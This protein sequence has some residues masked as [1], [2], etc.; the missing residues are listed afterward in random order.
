MRDDSGISV[1][2]GNGDGTFQPAMTIL[3]PFP[4]TAIGIGDWNRD[5]KLDIIA[6]GQ[7]GAISEAGVLLGNGDGTFT[8]GAT[9]LLDSSPEA[10][11]VEDFNRDGKL[12][13]AIAD[14]E[15]IGIAVLLGNGD[16]TFRMQF[17]IVQSFQVPLLRRT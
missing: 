3:P 13:V 12:D 17:S 15:G 8:P 5:G 11:A 7:S 16:G 6:V 10:V 1:L 9:Y 2:L 14:G 4:F